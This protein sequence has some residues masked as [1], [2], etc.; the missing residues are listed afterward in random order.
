[1]AE[2]AAINT[3]VED[4]DSLPAIALREGGTTRTRTIKIRL[5]EWFF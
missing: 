5:S 3:A 4:E 2:A 1:V